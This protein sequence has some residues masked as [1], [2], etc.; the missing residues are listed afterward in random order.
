MSVPDFTTDLVPQLTALMK[1]Y[2][3]ADIHA[4][5]FVTDQDALT[6]ILKGDFAGQIEGGSNSLRALLSAFLANPDPLLGWLNNAARV[7]DVNPGNAVAIFQAL[8]RYMIDNSE[9][10]LTRGITYDPPT[11][12]GANVGG[13]TFHRITK[14]DRDFA[15]ENI[16]IGATG[17]EGQVEAR[18]IRDANTGSSRNAEVWSIANGT[19]SD[20]VEPLGGG[21]SRSMTTADSDASAAANA[22]FDNFGGDKTTPTSISD[23]INSTSGDSTLAGDGSDV[24]FD[25]AAG[26]IYYPKKL[27]TE[28]RFSMVFK[29]SRTFTQ[30]IDA[31]GRSLSRFVPYFCQIAYNRSI[32]AGSGTLTLGVGSNTNSVILAAQTGWNL[33]NFLVAPDS[34]DAWYRNFAE[35]A[36]DLSV[37]ISGLVGEV[38][39]D[40]LIF[41]PYV[42]FAGHWLL[43]VGDQTPFRA[44]TEPGSSGDRMT[45]TDTFSGVDSIIQQFFF[46][47]L[48]LY[49]PHAVS[50]A[51]TIPEP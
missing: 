24:E 18:C 5:T 12:A 31:T 46:R 42:P 20:A 37:G 32:V 7:F 16:N 1:F 6:T 39:V 13:G 49:A 4:G 27:E 35:E 10:V 48:G 29:S 30:R 47:L 38:R 34:E 41:V 23:W 28:S 15:I 45:F 11:M 17:T 14:D 3:E 8:R 43:P 50:P 51:E 25:D 21:Q 26:S 44:G 9:S 36:L 40:S 2:K 19:G 22:S 33:L